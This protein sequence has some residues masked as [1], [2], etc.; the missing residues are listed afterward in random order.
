MKIKRYITDWKLAEA[1]RQVCEK[2][3]TKSYRARI[4]VIGYT[5]AGKT[6]LVRRLL[7]KPFMENIDSTEGIHTQLIETTFDKENRL[8]PWKEV[9]VDSTE[10]VKD[11]NEKVLS[12]TDSILE[13][14]EQGIYEGDIPGE[15]DFVRGIP[16]LDEN[17]LLKQELLKHL[18]IQNQELQKHMDTVRKHSTELMT[19]AGGF[20]LLTE[21]LSLGQGLLKHLTIQNQELQKHMDTVRKHNTELMTPAGGFHL[22]PEN[23]SLEKKLL[24]CLT[25]QNWELQKPMDTV[26]MHSTELMTPAGGFHP[27]MENVLL[28]QELLECWI[29]QNW[30]LQKHMD[31]VRRYSTELMTP[32]GVFHLLTENLS[33]GQEL[34]KHLTIQNQELQKHMDTV[35]KHSTELMTPAGVFHLLT[36]NLSL[37]QE[38]L[39]HLTI[40]NQE[41]QKHM[42]TVRKHS[43][44]LM[45]PA[46]GFHLLTE[47]LSLGQ[48][49]LKCLTIQNWEL[50]KHMDTVRMYSTELMTPAGGFHPP[51]ENVL[52]EQELLE[53]RIIQN[54]ELQKPMDPVRRYS[55]ELMTPVGGF[56]LPGENVMAEKKMLIKRKHFGKYPFFNI[57]NKTIGSMNTNPEETIKE[58]RS[59]TISQEE[60][61]IDMYARELGAEATQ[62]ICSQDETTDTDTADDSTDPVTIDPRPLKHTKDEKA[63]ATQPIHFRVTDAL[64]TKSKH[65]SPNVKLDEST[66]QQLN[67]YRESSTKEN[68]GLGSTK[69]LISLWDHGGHPH[70]YVTHHLFFDANAINLIVMDITKELNEIIPSNFNTIDTPSIPN[71]SGQ[72][73]DYWLNTLVEKSTLKGITPNMALILTH[74]DEFTG[75][76]KVY[77]SNLMNYMKDKM[78]CKYITQENIFVVDNKHGALDEFNEI[79]KILFKMAVSQKSW[80]IKQPTRW[81]KLEA[82]I[83]EEAK[84]QSL[85]HLNL[86]MVQQLAS[87]FGISK[88]EVDLFLQFHHSV[89]DFVH[90]QDEVLKE[91]VITDPQWLVDMFKAIITHHQFLDTRSIN[92]LMLQEYKNRALLSESLLQSLWAGNDVIFLIELMKKFHLLVQLPHN[93]GKY[94]VPCM[95]PQRK[96]DLCEAEPFKSMMMAYVSPPEGCSQD[97]RNKF[98]QVGSYHRLLATLCSS[99]N[100]KLCVDDHLAYSN[101]SFQV[102]Y[103]IIIA[104]TLLKDIRITIWCRSHSFRKTALQILPGIRA[105]ITKNLEQ[106]DIPESDTFLIM[107]PIQQRVDPGKDEPCMVKIKVADSTYE[108][109]DKICT[110]HSLPL[111]TDDFTWMEERSLLSKTLTMEQFPTLHF[112]SK[113]MMVSQYT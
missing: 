5:G 79:R 50:Q 71:S 54:W 83:H 112:I 31:P 89:G 28:E 96:L 34:L 55:T 80:G 72:L 23:L 17:L 73:L 92:Q 64:S 90:Y 40:Q 60:N 102:W 110:R 85:K 113:G 104:L 81:L 19:P 27:P 32:A 13:P 97:S 14:V 94:L 10:I 18:T 69:C 7:R 99:T 91:V 20:H 62:D 15:L 6:T 21:N 53:R 12:M 101:A 49:L 106:L 22:L 68:K 111:T 16:L 38:L 26:R 44:E 56:H 2:G 78:Y 61:T 29:I 57:R 93:T 47:N 77:V 70:Y 52:L 36:E 76:I 95:L 65:E 43:T 45:T 41:L 9:S 88:E 25:I 84:T 39:K 63:S 42:D 24:R 98:L 46:G 100:W 66:L 30:E 74:K 35:R 107:C 103:G 11:F 58:E 48:E 87:G 82:S 3:A 59:P 4:N 33:L 8:G 86:R 67:E 1:Y 37:G 109:Q 51:M 75:S 108:P 105:T